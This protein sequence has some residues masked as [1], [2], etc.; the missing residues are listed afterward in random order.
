VTVQKIAEGVRTYARA[1]D[2]KD[3][4]I[5]RGSAVQ[6]AAHLDLMKLDELIEKE[7]HRERS[8]LCEFARSVRGPSEDPDPVTCRDRVATAN[9]GTR[10]HRR[11]W[12]MAP[13]GM[14]SAPRTAGCRAH[15]SR[16][17][18]DRGV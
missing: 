1:D 8:L 9:A 2:A 17:V 5:A 13:R 6:C 12:S 10:W 4:A 16:D 11:R 14:V 3:N 7:V 18:P 15:L